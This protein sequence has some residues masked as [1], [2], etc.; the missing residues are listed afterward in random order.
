ME[1]SSPESS[2]EGGDGED[3]AAVSGKLSNHLHEI[4]FRFITLDLQGF[5]SGSMSS[6]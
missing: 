4:G 1:E 6:W 5:R 3:R 2:G